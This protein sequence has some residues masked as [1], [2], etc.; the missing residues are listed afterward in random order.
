MVGNSLIRFPDAITRF[1]LSHRTL[2]GNIGRLPRLQVAGGVGV[3]H[4]PD[5]M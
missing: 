4:V 3:D 2:F 5:A 1:K